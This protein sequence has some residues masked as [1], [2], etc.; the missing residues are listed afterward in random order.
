MAII[1]NETNPSINKLLN[2]LLAHLQTSIEHFSGDNYISNQ[3]SI[4][5]FFVTA[6]YSNNFSSLISVMKALEQHFLMHPFCN[7]AASRCSF[8]SCLLHFLEHA[9]ITQDV[10]LELHNLLSILKDHD[11]NETNRQLLSQC[12][13]KSIKIFHSFGGN[14]QS[15][16]D[17]P[18]MTHPNM[19]KAV[20]T[21]PYLFGEDEVSSVHSDSSSTGHIIRPIADFPPA[22][23]SSSAVVNPSPPPIDSS[24]DEMNDIS[25]I[26]TPFPAASSSS[27]PLSSTESAKATGL[28]PFLSNSTCEQ[29]PLVM[30]MSES[31]ESDSCVDEQSHCLSSSSSFAGA[32]SSATLEFQKDRNI[33]TKPDICEFLS[34]ASASSNQSVLT[35][36]LSTV[37]S[38]LPSASKFAMKALS[39]TKMMGSISKVMKFAVSP[40]LPTPVAAIG[41]VLADPVT[42]LV[43]EAVNAEHICQ[44][45]T[46]FLE[47]NPDQVERFIANGFP[48]TITS[49]IL[50]QKDSDKIT[51]VYIAAMQF[52]VQ[53]C[54]SHPQ[55]LHS[56]L[57]A[58]FLEA[59]VTMLMQNQPDI[60]SITLDTLKLLLTIKAA[61]CENRKCQKEPRNKAYDGCED[62]ESDDSDESSENSNTSLTFSQSD[63]FSQQNL[64][65]SHSFSNFATLS[66]DPFNSITSQSLPRSFSS[67]D[68]V[69]AVPSSIPLPHP[70][71][72]KF[73]RC[74]GVERISLVFRQNESMEMQLRASEVCALVFRG[75][76]IP[77]ELVPM[78]SFLKAACSSGDQVIEQQALSVLNDLSFVQHNQLILLR[79]DFIKLLKIMLQ[80]NHLKCPSVI[81]QVL[82]LLQTITSN[83]TPLT[84]SL[85]EMAIPFSLLT[86][87]ISHSDK[88]ISQNA[89]ALQQLLHPEQ[90]NSFI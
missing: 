58:N 57:E 67:D 21:I 49:F 53:Y 26:C 23:P 76:E 7:E 90:D 45:V 42:S 43:G 17:M 82:V 35:S 1:T 29:S 48:S 13:M 56:L 5:N 3:F 2:Q 62:E 51:K 30:C 36:A 10:A 75:R 60:R 50:S 70:C 84:K 9:I 22:F 64:L 15:D 73:C 8:C 71:Y 66:S 31:T 79:N 61:P 34:G 68:L 81:I 88:N 41:S 11:I 87:L 83:C 89:A 33:V 44:F 86:M 27:Q 63:S 39:D 55:R 54:E 72:H 59:L 46:N 20:T 80:D 19:F 14:T 12:E 78:V 40:F 52:F 85:L 77:S 28:F 16:I 65:R 25:A 37:S 32:S 24:S 18:E 4:Y 47:H 38:L 6:L 74:R 69:S